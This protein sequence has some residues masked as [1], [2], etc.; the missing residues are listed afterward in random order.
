MD[1]VAALGCVVCHNLGMGK[2]P[3]TLHHPRRGAGMGKRAS[4]F[5]VIPLCP[6]H[7]Q[8]GGHGV[9]IHAGQKTWEKNFGTETELLEQVREML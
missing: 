1:R 8:N 4:H 2:T 9:A 7:H 6:M 3:A 5:D